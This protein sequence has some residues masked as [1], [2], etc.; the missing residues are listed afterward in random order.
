M[1]LSP[2][3]DSRKTQQ[4]NNLTAAEGILSLFGDETACPLKP[5]IYAIPLK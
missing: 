1:F 4:I 2:P 3:S 5:A